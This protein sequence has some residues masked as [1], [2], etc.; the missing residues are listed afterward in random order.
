MQDQILEMLM[1]K[2][3]ITWQSMIYELIKSE[4]MNPWDID[5]SLLTKKYLET[6]QKLQEANF[7]ISGKVLLAS[8]ILLRIKSD[9][10]INEEI[11]NFD[12]QLYAK[13]DEFAEIDGIDYYAPEPVRES[14]ELPKLTIRTPMP[15]KRRI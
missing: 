3:E 5:I 10:L 8:S 13:E 9:K 11:F 4:Q 15:R 2:D 6:V 12:N 1:N 14:I 7:F